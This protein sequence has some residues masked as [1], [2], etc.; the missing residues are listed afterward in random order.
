MCL[1]H[2]THTRARRLQMMAS[3]IKGVHIPFP[4]LARQPVK[5]RFVTPASVD[6]VGSFLLRTVTKP[7]MN[8]DV[9]VEMPQVGLRMQGTYGLLLSVTGVALRV[10]VAMLHGCPILFLLASLITDLFRIATTQ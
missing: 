7:V 1:G 10:T 9:A 2:S 3:S 4:P 8:V 6:L 5:F